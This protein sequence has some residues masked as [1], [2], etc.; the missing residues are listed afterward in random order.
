[1]PSILNIKGYTSKDPLDKSPGFYPFLLT[2]AATL[3]LTLILII[4]FQGNLNYSDRTT[5]FV[6]ILNSLL[7]SFIV[8]SFRK[9]SSL[10]IFL[11]FF[12]P[13]YILMQELPVKAL[14]GRI[15]SNHKCSGRFHLVF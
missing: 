8:V 3:V 12:V 11:V 1:M 13:D 2:M 14:P 9:A 4:A 5:W 10:I 6:F 15:I 7:L